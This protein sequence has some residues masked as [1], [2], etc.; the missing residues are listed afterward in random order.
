MACRFTTTAPAVDESTM[1]KAMALK[2]SE[3]LGCTIDEATAMLK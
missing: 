2:L 1:L 3:K